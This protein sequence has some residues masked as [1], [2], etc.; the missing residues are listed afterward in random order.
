M[1]IGRKITLACTVL[2][3]FS[4]MLGTVATLSIHQIRDKLSVVVDDSLPGVYTIGRLDSLQLDLR[5]ATL[6]H[7][8]TPDPKVKAVKDEQAQTLKNL[9][10]GLLKEYQQTIRAPRDQEMFQRIPGFL[11]AYIRACEKV[12][13]LSRENKAA[14]AMAVYDTEG[15]STR[16]QLRTALKEQIEYK[17]TAA[18]GHSKS[19]QDA[20]SQGLFLTVLILSLALVSGGYLAFSIVRGINAALRQSIE[21]LAS[22]AEQLSKAAAQ[23]S[24]SS[25]ALAQGASEQAAAIE[26]TSASTQEITASS[27]RNRKNLDSAAATMEQTERNTN[28]ANLTL[29]RMVA[30]MNEITSSSE[31]I[32]KINRVIDEIAFQ[33]NIL[34]LNAA[35]EAARAGE[36]GMGFAVV[37]DEVRTLAQ[38]SA[39]AAKNTAGLIE[40]SIGK[41]AEGKLNLD[42]VA[43]AI[44]GLTGNTRA[45]KALMDDVNSGSHQQ[46]QAI[47]QISK[48]ISDMEGVTQ[49]TAAAAEQSASTSEELHAEA[50]SLQ[51]AVEQLSV[52]VGAAS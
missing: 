4:A 39:E 15:D 38:R 45:V 20:A 5:G 24:A 17:R 3:T 13:A 34:A 32:S 11:D 25:Q 8:A 46:A 28:E 1:T 10:P 21:Q 50:E 2:V 51:N 47:H 44:R 27:Q 26:E 42:R 31:N 9:A 41:S 29:D 33:T 14:E 7:V 19:A 12:R 23:V 36:A 49:R 43:T 37:A 6:H 48:S 35:V 16:K 52:L 22:G 30:S 18:A 40:Q